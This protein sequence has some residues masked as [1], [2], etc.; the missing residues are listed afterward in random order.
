MFSLN[1][2]QKAAAT[3]WENTAVWHAK[4]FEIIANSRIR[5]KY[6]PPPINLDHIER[7]IITLQY[8]LCIFYYRKHLTK[9][10]LK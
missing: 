5:I 1:I 9:T 3:A 4:L 6:E 2:L 10:V 7:M 8:C